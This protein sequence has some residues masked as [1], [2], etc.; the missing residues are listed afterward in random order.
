MWADFDPQVLAEALLALSNSKP[1]PAG[2]LCPNI[3]SLDWGHLVGENHEISPYIRLF[4]GPH[5]KHLALTVYDADFTWLSII[6]SLPRDYPGITDITFDWTIDQCS[7]VISDTVCQWNRLES[8]TWHGDL[9]YRAFVHLAGLPTLRKI[10]MSIPNLSGDRQRHL[11]TLQRPAFRALRSALVSCQNFFSCTSLIEITPSYLELDSITVRIEDDH[12]HD[13]EA[14]IV[15]YFL[16]ML[17]AQCSH[18]ALTVLELDDSR[19]WPTHFSDEHVISD[20]MF[21][22]LLAFTNMAELTIYTPHAFRLSNRILGDIAAS[23]IQLRWLKLGTLCGWAGQSQITLAG[24]IPLLALPKLEGLNIVINASSVD[25]TLDMPPTG[26][27]NTKITQLSLADS[28]IQSAHSV[29]AFLSD[30]LPNVRQIHSWNDAVAR[31]ASVSPADAKKY[32]VRWLEVAMLIETI[33]KVRKQE[34]SGA[35]EHIDA[36]GTT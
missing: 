25:Y 16:Q 19:R 29:A 11:A 4:L 23:W 22:P 6:H 27:S 21:R 7:D 5:T 1:T 2:P 31:N 14:F 28:V 36:S 18:T 33:A 35:R 26:L 17:N 3:R 12:D 10:D 9:S 15:G 34:R 32:R 13:H 24:L 8:F 20:D 30:V